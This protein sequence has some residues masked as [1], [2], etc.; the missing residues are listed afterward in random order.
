M[1]PSL[2]GGGS[3]SLPTS[4][5]A[6]AKLI[7][8]LSP[9]IHLRKL[10]KLLGTSFTTTR[11]HVDSLERDGEILRSKDGKY[12]RLYPVGT[13]EEMRAVY[14]VLQNKTARR[15]LRALGDG[16]EQELTNGG[17]SERLH[18]PRSTLSECV[19]DLSRVNLVKR[20]HTLDGRILY[21]VQ[22]SE[23]VSRLLASL[24]R[25]PL[26]VATDGFIDLWDL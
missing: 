14:A 11:Y 18:L 23:E 16:G 9:G 10:Q 21:G 12:D 8:S 2:A 13:T 5:R 3:P 22:K 20:S 1:S 19:M 15:I 17:L 7:V 4:K 26:G 25:N 6:Q 24:D